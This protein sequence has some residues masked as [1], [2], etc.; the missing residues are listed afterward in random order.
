[1]Q[2]IV[3]PVD[4]KALR[5]LRRECGLTQATLA[6]RLGVH[7]NTVARWERDEVPIRPAMGQLIL[8]VAKQG[9]QPTQ[10]KRTKQPKRT[11]RRG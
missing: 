6:Q 1:M 2:C 11:K 10:R 5:N 3:R 4:G 8:L 7:W 9:K